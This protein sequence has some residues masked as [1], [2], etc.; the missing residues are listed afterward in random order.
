MSFAVL[1]QPQDQSNQSSEGSPEDELK[2]VQRVLI[3]TTRV[4]S[5]QGK[6][7]RGRLLTK[8]PG[9]YSLVFDNSFSRYVVWNYSFLLHLFRVF[10]ELN[11]LVG[12]DISGGLCFEASL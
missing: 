4:A 11:L 2:S 6:A 5:T 1:H 9:V 3:P 7:V 12:N 10:S 8:Q